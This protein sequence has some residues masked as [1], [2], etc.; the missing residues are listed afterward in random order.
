MYAYLAQIQIVMAALIIQI[1][2]SF[3]LQGTVM[4]IL[5]ICVWLVLRLIVQIASQ[6][7]LLCVITVHCYL[8]LIYMGGVH[9][10]LMI[11][12]LIVLII[13]RVVCNVLEDMG[14]L[15]GQQGVLVRLVSFHAD[16]VRQLIIIYV[17]LVY[18]IMFQTTTIALVVAQCYQCAYNAQAHQY[19]KLAQ[20][21]T[22]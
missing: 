14:L 2:V 3:V 13:I 11:F 6:V 18:K 10:V 5:I 22:T 21:A 9:L 1:N 8:G 15:L 20:R 19:A 16:R 7:I 4:T 12:V 17:H